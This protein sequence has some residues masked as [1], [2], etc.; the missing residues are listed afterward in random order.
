MTDP[1]EELEKLL[2]IADAPVIDAAALPRRGRKSTVT[3]QRGQLDL[4]IDKILQA[5]EK[6]DES[7]AMIKFMLNHQTDDKQWRG[8]LAV[9]PAGLAAQ[10]VAEFRQKTN[11]PLEIPFFLL[12]SIISGMMLKKG[13]VL[14]SN[15]LGSIHPDIWTVVL[16]SSGAGKTYSQKKI[17]A[18]VDVSGMEFNGNFVS[19]A[20]FV[21]SLNNMPKGLWIRDEFAQFIKQ[22]ESGKSPLAEIKDYLLRLYDNSVIERKTKDCVIKIDEPALSILG[23]TVLETFGDNVSAESM[24]D[25]FAQRF[26]YVI[27]KSDPARPYKN[28]PL[29]KV[30]SSLFDREWLKVTSCIKDVYYV[31]DDIIEPALSQAF[32]SLFDEKVPESFFR[33]I[34]WR[35]TKYAMIYHVLRCDNS[36][37]LTAEDFGWSARVLSMHIKDAM[38]LLG[39]HNLS[40]LQRVITATERMIRN[41]REKRGKMPTMREVVQGVKSIKSVAQAQQIVSLLNESL[42]QPSSNQ[43]T[44]DTV[45]LL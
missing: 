32:N 43:Y 9:P 22:V 44:D 26:S 19:S 15:S 3:K 37:H 7:A 1:L 18:S 29:W 40:D 35:A 36:D 10:I 11:I 28:Y 39:E 20:A 42:R 17:T 13:T 33:R 25:G 21:D 6:S 30:N 27:A 8:M 12:L 38:W 14:K 31:D 34:I 5:M 45:Q 16:A 4:G 41:H 24:L 23:L 2:D